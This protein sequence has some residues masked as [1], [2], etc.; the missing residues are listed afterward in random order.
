MRH[1]KKFCGFD[2]FCRDGCRESGTA[3]YLR[4]LTEDIILVE[5]EHLSYEH[6]TIRARYT[7]NLKFKGMLL[8]WDD[9]GFVWVNLQS[10]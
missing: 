3:F 1:A 5:V 7:T 10:N 4:G 8:F 9:I 6:I 2:C